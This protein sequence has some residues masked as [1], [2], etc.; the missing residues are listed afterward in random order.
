MGMGKGL[1]GRTA[2]VTGSSRGIGKAIAQ[3]LGQAGAKVAICARDRKELNLASADLRREKINCISILI[4]VEKPDS[5]KTVLRKI[6]KEWGGLDILVNNV[7]GLIQSGQFEEL[8][9]M[10]WMSSF[11][12]N[13]MPTVRFCR[14]A[15]PLLKKSAHPR[16]IN[17]SSMVASQP[18]A[19]NPHYSTFKAAILNLTK[20]LSGAY[21][22]DGILVNSISPGIIHTEGWEQY[23][24][25]KAE[26]DGIPLDRC[27]E[28]ENKRASEKVPLKR[29]GK[30]REV[31]DLAAFLAS[32]QAS[33]I[34]GSNHRVDGGRVLSI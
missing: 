22:Q 8:D 24:S 12:L 6:R 34:T 13:L 15:L 1:K 14:E 16:I 27:A 9:D 23:I 25:T 5:A 29:L 3:A 26:T 10:A 32:D 11:Q 2:L 20:H 21:A 33:F 28:I 7:G 19:Y 17:I 31:A 30:V 4:D 18:G